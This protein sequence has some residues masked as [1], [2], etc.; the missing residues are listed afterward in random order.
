[1]ANFQSITP[2]QLASGPVTTSNVIIYTT[3]RITRTFVKD[4]NI[5]NTSATAQTINLNIVEVTGVAGTANALMYEL[6][7]PAKSIYRWTGVQ[8]MNPGEKISVMGSSADLTVFIS[9]AEAV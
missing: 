5:C 2:V 9:G 1:M 6:S 8:I 7:I 3:P 4:I